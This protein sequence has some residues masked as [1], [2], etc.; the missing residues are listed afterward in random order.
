MPVN[1]QISAVVWGLTVGIGT[2]V[3]IWAVIR[4]G[5]VGR[6]N[7]DTSTTVSDLTPEPIKPTSHEHLAKLTMA[8]GAV[9]MIHD[10]PDGIS[11]AHNP[12]PLVVKIIIV[13]VL[14]WTVIY[15]ILFAQSGFNFS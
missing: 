3:V 1:Q 11:K 13:S 15:V 5:W 6:P 2:I 4:G 9:P 12:V 14:V 10:F 8:K 7:A